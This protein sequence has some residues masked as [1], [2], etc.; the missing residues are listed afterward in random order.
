MT[1]TKASSVVKSYEAESIRPTDI[2]LAHLAKMKRKIGIIRL[3]PEQAAAEHESIERYRYA[4]SLIGV[5]LIEVDRLGNLLNGERRPITRDDVD[6]VISLHFETPK[7]Y[8][9]FSWAA[10]WNP[11]DFYVDWGFQ[12]FTD[13]QFSHDGY[14]SCSSPV[15]ERFARQEL[16]S[17]YDE[18]AH[19]TVNHTLSGPVFRAQERNDRRLVY[20]GINWERLSNKPGRFDH[21]LRPLDKAGV[22]DIFGPEVIQGT[23]V[24]EGFDGYKREVPFDGKSLI[25][26]IAMSGAV[27]ALSSN[28]HLRSEVMTSRLFEGAA[29]G[30]LV[31]ADAN[32]FVG[33][34]F[35]DVTVPIEITGE[36]S[37]DGAKIIAALEHYNNSPD[38]A[39]KLAK[40]LQ[41][42]YIDSYMLHKQLLGVYQQYI[43]K[44]AQQSAVRRSSRDKIAYVVLW[45]DR[46]QQFPKQA[47]ASIQNQTGCEAIIRVVTVGKGSEENIILPKVAGDLD[48]G[49]V[50][51]DDAYDK[52]NAAGAML[53]QVIDSLPED[54]QL[55][56]VMTSGC[57]LFSDYAVQM[58][59][60]ARENDTGAVCAIILRHYDPAEYAMSGTEYADYWRPSAANQTF[61]PA[62]SHM[63]L[64]RDFIER[65]GGAIQMMA[66]DTLVAY[67]ARFVDDM[68]VV[69]SPL[70][71]FDLKIY[72][73]TRRLLE[74]PYPNGDIFLNR[75]RRNK[76]TEQVP[77]GTSALV[78]S[79]SNGDVDA[80]VARLKSSPNAN[81][82]FFGRLSHRIT[83]KKARQYARS[84]QWDMA[85]RCYATII[86]TGGSNAKIWKQYAHSLK[87]QGLVG[88][89]RYSYRVAADLDP[90]DADTRQHLLHIQSK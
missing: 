58:S 63:L 32:G 45:P 80:F 57:D 52:P 60:A 16:G 49:M 73:R 74:S 47:I 14:F 41:D 26:E 2:E 87:E 25:R 66:Y 33:R 40:S 69:D 37:K 56:S 18:V 4:C 1:H 85:E 70:A 50:Y 19:A 77:A 48:I 51:V 53:L 12:T 68:A 84:S 36:A 67:L 6:F 83:L 21:L 27:L 65:N 5:D 29:A 79:K 78:E 90:N 23:R 86:S 7:A 46:K 75:Y 76:G 89:A 20:C 43:L 17:R 13:H 44:E 15:I 22:L 61:P 35:A 71:R 81:I 34:Y 10:L 9:C 42:R 30:A 88:P 8:D 55:I 31:M 82:S 24:W 38:E 3:W 64:K 28:A 11:V 54:I 39:F 72:E 59:R 62:A